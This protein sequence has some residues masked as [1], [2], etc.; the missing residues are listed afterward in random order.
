[1]KANFRLAALADMTLRDG[2]E[3]GGNRTGRVIASR[4]VFSVDHQAL[5]SDDFRLETGPL[6]DPYT[7]EGSAMVSLGEAPRFRI[8]AEGVQLRVDE[9]SGRSG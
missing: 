4:A 7:A 9:G 8:M 3:G 5:R 2:A 6:D 1:M